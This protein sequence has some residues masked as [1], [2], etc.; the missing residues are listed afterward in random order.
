MSEKLQNII[1][2]DDIYKY[3]CSKIGH[4]YDIIK[5]S[6]HNYRFCIKCGEFTLIKIEPEEKIG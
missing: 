4:H 6:R 5:I 3:Q 2:D 1:R